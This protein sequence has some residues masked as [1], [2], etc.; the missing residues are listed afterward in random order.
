MIDEVIA[1]LARATGLGLPALFA[2]LYVV[3]LSL[4]LSRP[5]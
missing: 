3:T 2:T 5:G 4:L 1:G